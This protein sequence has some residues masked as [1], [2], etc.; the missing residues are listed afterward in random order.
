MRNRTVAIGVA[1]GL[2]LVAGVAFGGIASADSHE[3]YVVEQGDQCVPVAPVTQGSSTAEEFYGY[4]GYSSR[5]SSQATEQYQADDTSILMLYEGPDGLSLV[6]VHDKWHQTQSEGTRGGTASFEVSNLPADGEWVAED[7][8]YAGQSDQFDHGETESELHWVWNDGRTDG[9]VYTGLGSS[10]AVEIDPRFN[11]EARLEPSTRF[12]DGTVTDWQLVTA[13]EGGEGFERVSLGSLSEPVTIRPGSCSAHASGTGVPVDNDVD[14]G[15]GI[16]L[17]SVWVTTDRPASRFDATVVQETD[18][19]NPDDV[20][21]GT[22]LFR[23]DTDDPAESVT[24]TVRIGPE[25]FDV[26]GL[27]PSDLTMFSDANGAWTDLDATIVEGDDAVYVRAQVDADATIG[28]GANAPIVTDVDVEDPVAGE[29]FEVRIT[30]SNHG[31]ESATTTAALRID[32]EDVTQTSATVSG[33]GTTESVVTMTVD[34]PGET[35][36]QAGNFRQTVTVQE[37]TREFSIVDVSVTEDRIEPG[38]TTEIVAVVENTGSAS[39]EYTANFTIAGGLAD[40]QTATV[41]S[42][43]RTEI[44]FTQSFSEA[45][46]YEVGVG[47]ETRSV[48][49]GDGDSAS[50]D[51]NGGEDEEDVSDGEDEEE[52]IHTGAPRFAAITTILVLLAAGT[53]IRFRTGRLK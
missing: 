50:G 9:A 40:V 31:S 21:G 12:E 36:I 53:A 19:S 45:G 27:E 42:G 39:G 44:T 3:G 43:E 6:I 46:T 2:L 23:L 22:S 10:F 13:T 1:V 24:F 4:S 11:D 52:T 15:Y 34:D 38:G 14:L 48:T 8:N 5:Y 26:I 32:G 30:F 51:V 47:N 18:V 28:I 41:E 37:A 20:S 16:E 35:T 7:D 29:P 17:E 25:L 49:V 33:D